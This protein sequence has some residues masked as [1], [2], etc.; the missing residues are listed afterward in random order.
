MGQMRFPHVGFPRLLPVDSL[1]AL[2]FGSSAAVPG[3]FPPK[4]L[5]AYWFR[6]QF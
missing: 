5:L 2:D 1:P 4:P 6:N 3:S